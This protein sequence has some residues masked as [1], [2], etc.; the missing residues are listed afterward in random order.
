[1]VV[2]RVLKGGSDEEILEWCFQHGYRPSDDEI[3]VWNEFMVKRGWHDSGSE[4]L[5]EAKRERGFAAREDIQTWFDLH[6]A[7]EKDATG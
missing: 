3:Q 4:E 7:E 6:S 2:D 5:R 1:M